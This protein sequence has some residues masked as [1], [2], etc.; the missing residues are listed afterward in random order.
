MLSYPVKRYIWE[1]KWERFRPIQE[2]AIT[3]IMQTDNHYII[4]SRTA[5]GKTEAAFL[6]VISLLKRKH[7]K[8]HI[9]D[10]KYN[11]DEKK[12]NYSN[13]DNFGNNNINNI[14]DINDIE[15]SDGSDA[16]NIIDANDAG[17]RRYHRHQDTGVRVLYIS[18]LVA[19]VNDQFYRIEGL[20]RYMDIRITRWHGEA[21]LTAKQKLLE[22]P[23][24]I[25]LI[26]PE[27][28]EALFINK[29]K[30]LQRLFAN[31]EFIIVD[32]IHSFLD[33]RRGVQL[34]SLIF[35]LKQIIVGR[36]RF[37]GLSATLGDFEA[38]R[39]FF[40]DPEHTKIL[41]DRSPHA[42]AARFKYIPSEN[43]EL[44]S[45]LIDDLYARTRKRKS[46]VFPNSRGRVEE[47]AV[48]LKM[49]AS[50]EN[51]KHQYFAHH[52]SI[53]RELKEAAEAVT[54]SRG[55]EDFTIVCT[56]TLEMGVDIGTVDLVVQVDSTYSVSSLT[57][58]FGRSG[59]RAGE[60]SALLMYGTTPWSFLQSLACFEL[61]LEGFTEPEDLILYPIDLLFHQ[62]LS[63]LKQ[64]GGLP[65]DLF[66]EEVH[67]IDVFKSL[68]LQDVDRLLAFMEQTAYIEKFGGEYILGVEGEKLA[69]HRTFYSVFRTDPVFK[70]YFDDALIG[71]LTAS[72]QLSV[73]HCIYLGARTW[74]I[75][76]MDFSG[77]SIMV[78]PALEGRKPTFTGSGGRV[79]HWVRLKML[80]IL[81]RDFVSAGYRCD[82]AGLQAVDQLRKKFSG[83]NIYNPQT[84][85][86]IV[87]SDFGARLYTFAGTRINRTLDVLLKHLYGNGYYYNESRSCFDLPIREE[88]II[89]LVKTLQ[90][91][92]N[93]FPT[94]LMRHLKKRDSYFDFSK[95]GNV[96][97][98]FFKSKML[99]LDDF[100]IPAAA[101]FLQ[102]LEINT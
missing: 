22:H 97:P 84:Q 43:K 49:A 39:Q 65:E 52:S 91:Q 46:L 44:P 64:Q 29:S 54:R 9:K 79:H 89:P 24:G 2:A 68:P 87:C 27:S 17:Y 88:Q 78:E 41:R 21:S 36:P 80:E 86:P 23:Q 30:E 4:A 98:T 11:T 77:K 69:N 20:C 56:S 90:A 100:D 70:V 3:R 35:R 53:S 57:H 102:H 48:R 95:W 42:V 82:E 37:I 51:S 26:T 31:L 8:K 61:Y 1:K 92:L 7:R 81:S 10:K 55:K 67:R 50:L 25:L 47:I 59:R 19:L 71:E 93:E 5:S 76:R 58:R 63:I 94:I 32:E 6:P 33:S 45:E 83:F 60:K 66:L 75:I 18:P 38:V 12:D 15:S 101:S 40:G 85:R 16:N 99:L 34:R 28:I 73:D 14:Y 74:R 96:L 62:I 13:N 72:P